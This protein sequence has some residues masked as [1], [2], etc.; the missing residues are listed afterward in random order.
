MSG[1]SQNPGKSRTKKNLIWT[2]TIVFGTIGDLLC[3]RA[4]ILPQGIEYYVTA[5]GKQFQQWVSHNISQLFWNVSL[6]L[7]M[8]EMSKNFVQLTITDST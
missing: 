7:I 6:L 2:Y 4:Q 5:H 8:S 3:N 1:I